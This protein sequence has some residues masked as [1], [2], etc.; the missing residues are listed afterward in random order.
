[1]FWVEQ[2]VARK[3]KASSTTTTLSFPGNVEKLTEGLRDIVPIETSYT[4]VNASAHEFQRAGIRFTH[5]DHD[6]GG[7]P[8]ET[9]FLLP[10]VTRLDDAL[11]R[12][13]NWYARKEWSATK[14]DG[15]FVLNSSQFARFVRDCGLRDLKDMSSGIVDIVYKIV[16]SS[17]DTTY[18]DTTS[19][20]II[21]DCMKCLLLPCLLIHMYIY[22]KHIQSNV[23]IKEVIDQCGPSSGFF[24]VAYCMGGGYTSIRII[25]NRYR[26]GERRRENN[27]ATTLSRNFLLYSAKNSCKRRR[28]IEGEQ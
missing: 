25:I 15:G 27:T 10:H 5:I 19:I 4:K 20:T 22:V 28:I 12:L 9:P 1:L 6:M 16:T 3:N 7:I 17:H 13:F 2:G 21:I 24:L 11:R 8:T 14:D 23:H 26:E 18:N